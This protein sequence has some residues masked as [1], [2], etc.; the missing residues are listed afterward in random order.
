MHSTIVNVV[1]SDKIL[2]D[3]RIMASRVQDLESKYLTLQNSVTV[4]VA[5]ARGYKDAENTH[6]ISKKTLGKALT[7]GQ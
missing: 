6:F 4:S 3:S 5:Y 7:F 1:E 2:K